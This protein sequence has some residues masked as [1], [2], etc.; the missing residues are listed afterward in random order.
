M[1]VAWY[2]KYVCGI[3]STF[4]LHLH[5][6][7]QSSLNDLTLEQA[8]LFPSFEQAMGGG[9]LQFSIP[10]KSG[11]FIII[12]ISTSGINK[13]GIIETN[14]IIVSILQI[15]RGVPLLDGLSNIQFA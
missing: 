6:G 9:W 8:S 10:G 2:Y 15:Q 3:I 11:F 1:L 7:T 5:L 13:N 14:I 4:L 12:Q